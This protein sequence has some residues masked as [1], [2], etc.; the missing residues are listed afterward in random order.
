MSNL[1]EEVEISFYNTAYIKAHREVEYGHKS[2]AEIITFFETEE[3]IENEINEVR[4]YL[5]NVDFTEV[6]IS[7]CEQEEYYYDEELGKQVQRT[8]E[9]LRAILGTAGFL[10]EDINDAINSITIPFDS[11]IDSINLN[12]RILVQEYTQAGTMCGYYAFI[13]DTSSISDMISNHYI[14]LNEQEDFS[15]V[16]SLELNTEK[17][18]TA[19][20]SLNA[21]DPGYAS[22]AIEATNTDGRITFGYSTLYLDDYTKYGEFGTLFENRKAHLLNN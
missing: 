19:V 9:E 20:S 12:N 17:A 4:E 13:D 18:N 3:F 1:P 15:R 10:E 5:S 8:I 22:T 2:Y 21:L 7:R 6:A 16:E 14:Y 11:T